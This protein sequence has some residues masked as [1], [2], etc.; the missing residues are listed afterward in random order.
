MRARKC[1]LRRGKSL[2]AQVK[3]GFIAGRGI[4][5]DNAQFHRA[6][7]HR[8]SFRQQLGGGRVFRGQQTP[9]GPDLMTQAA[10]VAP[11]EFGSPLL[12]AYPFES[13]IVISHYVVIFSITQA[14]AT[15]AGPERAGVLV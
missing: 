14:S 9:H 1:A 7:N 8:K 5:F 6:I 3:L 4:L 11:V 2:N 12:L 13:R 15:A 10:P